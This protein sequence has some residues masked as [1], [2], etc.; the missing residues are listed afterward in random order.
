MKKLSAILLFIVLAL[1]GWVGSAL[2]TSVYSFTALTGGG[3]GALDRLKTPAGVTIAPVTGD[4]AMGVVGGKPYF[5]TYNS[6][7]STP[8]SS[9]TTIRPT[10]NIGCWTHA[11][12]LENGT[13]NYITYWTGLHTLGAIQLTPNR[14]LGTNASGLPVAIT[15]QAF[16]D[17]LPLLYNVSAPTKL[18]QFDLSA[19]TAGNTRKM[20]WRDKDFTPVDL[21][22]D[23]F[24]GKITTV[25]SATGGAGFNLPHGT[26]PSS[27]NDGDL[28]TT[29]SGLYARINGSTVGPF[30][31]TPTC[32]ATIPTFTAVTGAGL[33]TEET[34]NTVTVSITN[35]ANA[36][37]SI[38][39]NSGQYK[40]NSGSYT[41]SPALLATGD[42]VT[43][44]QTSSGSYSTETTSTLTVASQSQAY[45]VT[46]GGCSASIPT[47]TAVT[48]SATSTVNESNTVT[49]ALTGCSAGAPISIAG[50]SGQYKINSGSYTASAGTV[51]NGDSV[52]VKQT[53]SGSADTLTTTTLTVAGSTQPYNVT[54]AGCSASIPTFTAVTGAT[55]ATEYTSNT[56]TVTLTNCPSG[57]AI[58]IAGN[59]GLYKI[60]SGSYTASAG[61]VANGD[62]VTVKQTSSGSGGTKTT[63]TLTV[64]AATQGYDVTTSQSANATWSGD[65]ELEQIS[66]GSCHYSLNP[67][68]IADI[69][70]VNYHILIKA[71]ASAWSGT[72]SLAKLYM[73]WVNTGYTHTGAAVQACKL[74]RAYVNNEATWN[75]YSTGNAW[76]TPGGDYVSSN[77]SCGSANVISSAGWM[78]WDVTAIV[79]DAITNNSG[80]VNILIKYT[81]ENGASYSESFNSDNATSNKPYLAITQ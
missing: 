49:M 42:S 62:S 32:T 72:I 75:S 8:T 59:S 64:A 34:S 28:W 40:I 60:N 7:C 63:T 14:A 15:G 39:G 36:T 20:Y 16:G 73:Y 30:S 77:P 23:T 79:Q 45:N 44:K 4:T 48:D 67:M 61:T 33:S 18:G 27:P 78:N 74:T 66:P 25:A 29:T 52:K 43:V 3:A 11:S 51:A 24:T 81:T 68:L 21:A 76:T 37:I 10:S 22:G 31:S 47:F 46:T 57:A 41:A 58:S 13:V 38:A 53:S 6:T 65:T 26:V 19:V 5:Y 71:D 50:N 69:T 55:T 56:V 54:T 17:S 35:C 2:G 1:S 80:I 70:G 12:E 9:P